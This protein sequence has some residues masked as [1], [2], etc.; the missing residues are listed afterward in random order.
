ME[1]TSRASRSR[2]YPPRPRRHAARHVV[3]PS[4][5]F[6]RGRRRDRDRAE[7][8][9]VQQGVALLRGTQLTAEKRSGGRHYDANVNESHDE[10]SL[11]LTPPRGGVSEI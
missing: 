4:R 1:R 3:L 2:E 5:R 8:V 11:P 10:R 6:V 7:V 9:L